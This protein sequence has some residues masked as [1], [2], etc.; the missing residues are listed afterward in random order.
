MENNNDKETSQQAQQDKNSCISDTEWGPEGARQQW[1]KVYLKTLI[2]KIDVFVRD[3]RGWV[4]LY[5]IITLS[6]VT[7]PA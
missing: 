5:D 2:L 4:T 6:P 3:M 7:Y 1:Q